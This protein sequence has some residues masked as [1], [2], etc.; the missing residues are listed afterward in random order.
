MWAE[1]PI[2]EPADLGPAI[3]RAMAQVKSGKPA[4]IDVLTQPR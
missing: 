1:G 4:L 3:A 2:S